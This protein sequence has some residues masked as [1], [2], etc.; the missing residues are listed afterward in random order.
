MAEKQ[1]TDRSSTTR[2]LKTQNIEE[3]RLHSPPSDG[4]RGGSRSFKNNGQIS[5]TWQVQ[6]L[7]HFQQKHLAGG[8]ITTE[9]VKLFPNC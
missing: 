7:L 1:A 2:G 6:T 9:E 8:K 3:I 5:S 4:T